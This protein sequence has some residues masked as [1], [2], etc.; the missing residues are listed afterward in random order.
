M[1][2]TR[3][4]ELWVKE[5]DHF[6]SG[7]VFQRYVLPP[8]CRE[9]EVR[10]LVAGGKGGDVGGMCQGLEGQRQQRDGEQSTEKEGAHEK[11]KTS[12]R[13]NWQSRA[14]VFPVAASLVKC[15]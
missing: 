1:Y 14:P 3:K 12:D 4:I 10:G 5:D 13:G 15:Q 6:L 11:E 9:G 8:A 2:I 7:Q